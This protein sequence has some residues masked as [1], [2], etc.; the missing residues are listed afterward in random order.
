MGAILV[1]ICSLAIFCTL[2]QVLE[3][4]DDDGSGRPLLSSETSPLQAG[5]EHFSSGHISD[6][7]ATQLNKVVALGRE[8]V[9]PVSDSKNTTQLSWGMLDRE[10]VVQLL[11]KAGVDNLSPEQIERL[12]RWQHVVDLYGPDVVS[13]GKDRCQRFRDSVPLADR[14]VGVAG[15]F[16]TGTNALD[17]HLRVRMSLRT[18]P[19]LRRQEI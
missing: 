16:N 5:L 12:P 17:L 13:V 15:M 18:M 7:N 6:S 8:S 14:I 9:L 2:R 10:H 4:L 19:D 3:P 11:E 1:L